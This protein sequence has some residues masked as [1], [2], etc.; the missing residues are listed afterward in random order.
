MLFVGNLVFGGCCVCCWLWKCS[1]VVRC[2]SWCCLIIG[3]VGILVCW[4]LRW[5]FRFFGF[6]GGMVGCDD[7]GGSGNLFLF[8]FLGDFDMCYYVGYYVVEVVVM[9]G[10]MVWFF[11]IE[12]DG[13][14][15]YWW[16][17]DGVMDGVCE[18]FVVKVYDL[19]G[20]VV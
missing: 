8:V 7:K 16:D 12:G 9:E 18:L 10:L 11:G 4:R 15:F 3:Y 20:M 5:S 1:V 19:K 17:E 14:C 13:D 2:V 6:I